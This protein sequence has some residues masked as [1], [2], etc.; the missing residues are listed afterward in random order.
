LPLGS[1]KLCGG[2]LV[3]G[4]VIL[5]L[6]GWVR[7]GAISPSLLAIGATVLLFNLLAAGGIMYPAV[8]GSLWLL[9][10]L[11]LDLAEPEKPLSSKLAPVVAF[12][13]CAALAVSQYLSGYAPVLRS[14]GAMMEAENAAR[15]HVLKERTLELAAEADPFAAEPW[16]SLAALRL[17]IWLDRQGPRDLERFGQ[18]SAQ[19]LRLKPQSSSAFRT[20]GNY[21]RQVFEKSDSP[22][23][24]EAAVANLTRAVELYPNHAPLRAD[25]AL[26]LA[27]ALHEDA[28]QRE[29]AKSLELD[30]ATPHADKRLPAELRERM[31]KMAGKVSAG[32]R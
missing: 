28:A 13:V 29:A 16:H 26:A 32:S 9:L 21:W 5:A 23:H 27:D 20:V 24:A 3:G 30:G 19:F 4:I 15:D 10:G 14:Q 7:E 17:R 1:E 18:A 31:A 8:A 25:L 2:L 11:G 12:A 22:N 6:R